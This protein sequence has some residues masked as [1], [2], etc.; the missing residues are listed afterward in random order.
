M[1]AEETT[2]PRS[3]QPRRHC[4]I[5]GA[6]LAEG[7]SVCSIC[8]TEL[9][10][11]AL[12]EAEGLDQV[13]SGRSRQ[14]IRFLVLA[15]VTI[16]ILAG[17]VVLGLNLAQEP[18]EPA[19]LP[20]FT[21]TLTTT[22]TETSTA[23]PTPSPTQTLP[24]TETPTPVPPQEYVVQS[25][26]TLLGIALDND[27]TIDELTAYNNLDS[28]FIVEGQ[29]LLIPPPT[30]TPGPTPTPNPDE[31]TPTPSAFILHTVQSGDTLSTIAERYS[32]TMDVIRR[33][34]DIPEDS[35]T[36]Q[37][38]QVLTIPR[39]TPTPVPQTLEAPESTPT[40]SPLT[41]YPA[42]Q[43]LYPPD[44]KVFLGLD[45]SV[46]VQWASIGILE[47]REYYYVELIAPTAEGTVTEKAYVRAT[48]WRVPKTLFP[49]QD[50]TSNTFSWRVGVVRQVTEEPEPTYKIISSMQGRRTF[51]WMA[52]E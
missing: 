40:P 21:P 10:T 18:V 47:E 49:A 34:N 30:P 51:I 9:D 43:M 16:V 26:D 45:A 5:C 39:N 4:P 44:S 31:P 38:N 29:V 1:T 52:E 25:G 11:E 6:R 22:P 13:G 36:I 48:V 7:T 33:A 41:R 28:E 50:A 15:I 23:T 19:E 14:I 46:V 27:M 12:E 32:V 20:T 35:E 2:Q 42:P 37:A 3:D 8:G 17:S 24:P